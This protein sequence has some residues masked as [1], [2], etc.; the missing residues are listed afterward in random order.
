MPRNSASPAMVP[1]PGVCTSSSGSP[2]GGVT[3]RGTD[4]AISTLEA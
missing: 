2:S 4:T 1:T 3:G